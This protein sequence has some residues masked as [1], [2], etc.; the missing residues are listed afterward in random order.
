MI[1]GKDVLSANPVTDL[2]NLKKNQP[3]FLKLRT[4]EK[5]N[6]SK[7]MMHLIVL[8][9]FGATTKSVFDLLFDSTRM[10]RPTD[11]EVHGLVENRKIRN[12][13]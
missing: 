9:N 5:G 13:K 6:A 8:E 7:K 4:I 1:I 11:T 2:N 10:T 12:V 3:V